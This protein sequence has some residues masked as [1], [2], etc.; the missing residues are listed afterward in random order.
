MKSKYILL[1]QI[2]IGI[3]IAI[4]PIVING[5]AYDF[6]ESMGD[7]LVAEFIM[8]TISLIIGMLVISKSLK[9]YS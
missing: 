6:S 7:L 2:I 9:D 4:A 1:F 8:R 3:I 5:V